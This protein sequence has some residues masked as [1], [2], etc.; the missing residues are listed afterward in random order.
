MTFPNSAFPPLSLGSF[1]IPSQ[2]TTP[3]G[4]SAGPRGGFLVQCQASHRMCQLAGD[5]GIDE[6]GGG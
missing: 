4:E 6:Q 1:T 5:G 2:N 3:R